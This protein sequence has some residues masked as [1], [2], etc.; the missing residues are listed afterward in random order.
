VQRTLDLVAVEESIAQA[1]V[2]VRTDIVRGV[3][4]PIDATDGDF[5]STRIDGRYVIHRHR[6]QLNDFRPLFFHTSPQI[7]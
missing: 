1:C 4:L 5:P 3:H 7:G 6:N 2:A